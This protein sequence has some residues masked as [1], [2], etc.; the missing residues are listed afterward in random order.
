M[1]GYDEC[2]LYDPNFYVPLRTD[3]LLNLPLLDQRQVNE[4]VTTN[5]A[6]AERHQTWLPMASL[7]SFLFGNNLARAA[8]A[9]AIC[10]VLGY[11]PTK[12]LS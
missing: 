5:D 4:V 10:L 7:V 8:R 1:A 11:L 6:A 12:T 9:L 2:N 3:I